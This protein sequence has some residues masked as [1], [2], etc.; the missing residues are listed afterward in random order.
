MSRVLSLRVLCTC[1]S[2]IVCCSRYMFLIEYICTWS[3]E[4]TFSFDQLILQDGQ[5]DDSTPYVQRQVI[6]DRP[7][8]VG[9]GFNIIGGKG[10]TGIF[11][12]Y[13]S[14][15]SV[16][17]LSYLLKPGDQIIEVRGMPLSLG[18]LHERNHVLLVEDIITKHTCRI[19]QEIYPK[20]YRET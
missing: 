12:S 14:P 11:I 4:W 16:S 17:D 19:E 1:R 8:G 6:L 7:E 18:C 13:I 5:A 9:L 20:L 15:G 2:W 3:V 10:D